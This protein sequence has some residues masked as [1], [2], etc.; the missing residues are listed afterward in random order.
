[1]SSSRQLAAIMFTDMVGYTAL[2]QQNEILAVQQRD[3]SKKILEDALRKYDGRLLQYYGDG[4][5]SVFSSA[6]NAVKS[7]IEIQTLNRDEKIA[8]RIGI[9]TGDVVFDDAGI[10]G[11]SVNVAS[12]IESLAVAGAVFISEKLFNEISNQG[13][14]AKPLGYFELKNVKQPV[15]VFAISSPGIVIPSRDEV[16][17]KL[18]QSP[19]S[20]AILPFASLSSDPENDFFCDGITEEL[21]NVLSKIEGLQVTSRTSSFAFKGKTEDIREIAA[22][23]NVQKVLEGSVRKAGN[24]LRITAQLINASDGYHIWSESYDRNFEDIFEIQDDISRTIANKLRK[25]LA[26]SDHEKAIGKSTY[27]KYG[28][29]QEIYAGHSLQQ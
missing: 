26:A 4:T 6:L 17:G 27:S 2:M 29:L 25:N 11:D 16:K 24:K 5:L 28:G 12:R 10:Y 7:S 18:K 15:Q 21:L 8:M 22:K 23:L 13:L 9:H 14:D 3:K 20:I 1:M 19:N